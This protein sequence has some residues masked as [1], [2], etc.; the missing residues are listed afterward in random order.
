MLWWLIAIL[1]I[2]TL[3]INAQEPSCPFKVKDGKLIVKQRKVNG[4][5]VCEFQR[6]KVKNLSSFR[7]PHCLE[8][9]TLTELSIVKTPLKD[10]PVGIASIQ[11]LKKLSLRFTD[12]ATLPEDIADLQNLEEL[13]LRGTRVKSLP[14]GLN[15]LKKID[16]RMV[17]LNKSQQESLRQQYPEVKIFFSSPCNCN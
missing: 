1:A 17:D 4:L 12:I 7:F 15:H 9:K 6:L 13:D 3:S 11:S 2:S 10:F 16:L 5:C 14:T 8:Y